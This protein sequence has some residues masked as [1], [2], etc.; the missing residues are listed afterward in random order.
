MQI[1]VKDIEEVKTFHPFVL[2]LKIESEQ[3]LI[4]LW[5]RF[6]LNAKDFDENYHYNTGQTMRVVDDSF[7]VFR[8]ID[9][10]L[11]CK[12]YMK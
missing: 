10:L 8:K 2:E 1:Q 12:S 6:N 3:D 11:M 9:D 5:C 4:D 7:D